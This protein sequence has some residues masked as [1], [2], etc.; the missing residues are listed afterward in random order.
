VTTG[1]PDRAASRDD[2]RSD[3]P[4][5]VDGVHQA[6]VGTAGRADVPD[7]S[8]AGEQRLSGVHHATK[9]CVH[10][11]LGD[12]TVNPISFEI[13]G[14][15]DVHVGETGEKRHVSQLDHL[16]VGRRLCANGLDAVTEMTTAG[17]DPSGP[18]I[19]HPAAWMKTV[20]ADAAVIESEANSVATR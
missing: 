15:M 5:L 13:A 4:S 16:G 1:N 9:R 2:A 8:E 17:L 19:Q 3:D 10:R 14:Q 6:H 12:V 18:H 7:R 11:S 20:W